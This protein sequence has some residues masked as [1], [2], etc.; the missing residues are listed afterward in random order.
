MKKIIEFKRN[1]NSKYIL[2]YTIEFAEELEEI[3]TYK[4]QNY[5]YDTAYKFQ[6]ELQEKFDILKRNPYSCEKYSENNRYRRLIV[7]NY[8]IF[9]KIDY[10]NKIIYLSHIFDSRRK[11]FNLS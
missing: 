11:Y 4:S 1:T 2:K 5:Y 6:I 7:E 9:Y 10:E 8:K 3:F